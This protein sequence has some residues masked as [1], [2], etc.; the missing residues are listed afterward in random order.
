P[1]RTWDRDASRTALGLG[2]PGNTFARLRARGRD[3]ASLPGK[4]APAIDFLLQPSRRDEFASSRRIVRHARFILHHRGDAF[5]DLA[6]TA[7]TARLPPR[8]TALPQADARSTR[9]PRSLDDECRLPDFFHCAH[10]RKWTERGIHA[11]AD[12]ARLWI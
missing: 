7:G 5:D 12:R 3:C 11:R 8:A 9:G 4:P 6:T 2:H 10:D 1:P